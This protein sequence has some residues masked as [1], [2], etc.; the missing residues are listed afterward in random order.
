MII[1]DS[2]VLVA[3]AVTQDENHERAV[4]IIESIVKGMFGSA[5]ISDHIFAETV[6]VTLYK[7]KSLDNA[8]ALGEYLRDAT[9]ILEN[10]EFDFESTWRL[11]KNQKTL[12]LSFTDCS[13]ISLARRYGIEYIATFDKEFRR[14]YGLHII[15]DA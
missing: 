9:T 4:R 12:K 3:Y 1:I 10:D 14:I 15:E 11:F 2:S 5:H 8:V 13:I 6:T 7:S